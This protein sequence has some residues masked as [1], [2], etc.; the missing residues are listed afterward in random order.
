MTIAQNNK[1]SANVIPIATRDIKK[2]HL[3]LK[4]YAD[5][6]LSTDISMLI[7]SNDFLKRMS[8]LFSRYL[9][10]YVPSE[11]AER[12]LLITCIEAGIQGFI[13]AREQGHAEHDQFRT[14]M[15]CALYP[16]PQALEWQLVL[17]SKSIEQTIWLPL[18]QCLYDAIQKQNVSPQATKRN[19][20]A[21]TSYFRL[22]PADYRLI[23]LTR[24][25]S[26]KPFSL[27]PFGSHL[28]YIVSR[29]N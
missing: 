11:N 9:T 4:Y 8:I 7:Y 2:P 21:D 19:R 10:H 14:F 13:R 5:Q 18:E 17:G 22:S 28:D 29:Y 20:P 15:R 6:Y 23:V 26:Q 25:L 16:L 24:F 3:I 27:T 1:G 12:P